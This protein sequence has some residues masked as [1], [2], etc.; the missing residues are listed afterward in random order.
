MPK[1]NHRAR[2]AAAGG[3]GGGGGPID[4][5]W[6]YF[7][8][9][10]REEGHSYA[11]RVPADGANP[12]YYLQYEKP[13]TNG[14]AS[15]SSRGGAARKRCRM[16][17]EE[18]EESSSGEPEPA[19][20]P[21]IEEDYRVFLQNVRLVGHGGFV[22]EHEGNVIRYD[23]SGAALSSDESSDESVMGA[24]EPDPRRRKA[25][26]VEE[27]QEEEEDVKNE[28]AV[29]SRK[30]DFTMVK[31]DQEKKGKRVVDLPA[32]GEDGAMVAEEDRKKK[33]RKEFNFHSFHSKGK[34]DT[35]PV[36]NL[37]DKKKEVKNPKDKKV[38]GKKEVAL[39]AKGKDCQLAEGVVIK[40]EEEDGQL[41]I[42]PAVEKLATTTR[43]TNLS[44]GHKTAPRIASLFLFINPALDLSF[45]F[46]PTTA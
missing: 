33:L 28:V 32:R 25:K 37:K 2:S 16:E 1:P 20:D 27:D 19:P 29:P 6:K 46:R 17:E 21:D 4:A 15:T 26:I 3:G 13:L 41:Q 24:P 11:V 34:D 42:V 8:D 22:L 9:N 35:T 12:S 5:D 18:E 43:L 39:S 7:L 36:K 31:E 44:N 30:K 40:V 14:A 10:V 45:L 38:H 23:A